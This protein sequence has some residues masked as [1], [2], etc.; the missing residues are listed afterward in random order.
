[1]LNPITAEI[2]RAVGGEPLPADL[3]DLPCDTSFSPRKTR[4]SP[5][6][7]DREGNP[8]PQILWKGEWWDVP[9]NEE[10][11]EWVCDSVCLTPDDDEVEPDHPSSWLYLLGLI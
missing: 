5:D 1:M 8:W 3:Y 2:V 6:R 4:P 9:T 11:E 7:I 10:V